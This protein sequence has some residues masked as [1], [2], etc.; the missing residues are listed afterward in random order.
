[1]EQ[2]LDVG[3]ARVAIRRD[4]HPT[5]LGEGRRTRADIQHARLLIGTRGFKGLFEAMERGEWLP[6]AG[7]RRRCSPALCGR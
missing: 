4:A 3:A 6:A 1:V 5:V 2:V 7:G